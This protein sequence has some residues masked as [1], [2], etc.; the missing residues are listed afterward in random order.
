MPPVTPEVPDVPEDKPQIPD[1]KPEEN[2]KVISIGAVNVSNLN[3]RSGAGTSYAIK[4]SVTINHIVEIVGEENGW[5]KIKY[6]D[7]TAYVS[8]K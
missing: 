7:N 1:E 4:G 8:S 5:Y 3:V 2:L 6:K